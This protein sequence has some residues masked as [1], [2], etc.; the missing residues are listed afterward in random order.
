V[1]HTLVGPENIMMIKINMINGTT[2]IHRLMGEK[3]K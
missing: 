3:N 2:N 1:P